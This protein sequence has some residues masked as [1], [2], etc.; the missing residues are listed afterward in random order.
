[1]VDHKDTMAGQET[2][3]CEG[4]GY[5][6]QAGRSGHR[7]PCEKGLKVQSGHRKKPT[8]GLQLS[9]EVK[10]IDAQSN[11]KKFL[12]FTPPMAFLSSMRCLT[13]W[14]SFRVRVRTRHWHFPVFA[15]LSSI[16]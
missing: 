3:R 8:R 13:G 11:G 15:W 9:L 10:T 1:M 2:G 16:A 4:P 5:R 6:A 12:V 7:Q 14:K